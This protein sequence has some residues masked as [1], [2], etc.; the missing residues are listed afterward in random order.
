MRTYDLTA[1]RGQTVVLYFNV[2]NNGTGTQLWNYVD[3][4]ELGSCS[5]NLRCAGGRGGAARPGAGPCRMG[6]AA[7]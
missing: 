1:Y 7:R 5:D 2:Y 3:K 6:G 4:A